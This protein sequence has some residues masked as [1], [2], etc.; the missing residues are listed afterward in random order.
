M[1]NEMMRIFFPLKII[2]Y[3][4]HEYG[5][6]GL[7]DPPEKIT[8]AEAV[9]YEDALKEKV[10][11]L[12]PSVEV[13]DGE[14]WGVMAAGLT[15]ALSGEEI[16]ELLN[17]VVGQNADGFGEILEQRPIKTPDGEIY[18]SLWNDENYSIKPEKEMKNSAPDLDYSGPVMGGM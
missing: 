15:E 13:C 9:A 17:F 8:S 1:A 18:V 14:L 6:C 12:Y 10:H 7:D 16:A 2:T 5:E 4:Q 11:S 3:P